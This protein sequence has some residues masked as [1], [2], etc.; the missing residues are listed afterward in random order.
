VNVGDLNTSNP[1]IN[2]QPTVNVGDVDTDSPVIGTPSLNIGDVQTSDPVVGNVLVNVGDVK[3][4]GV[5][6]AGQSVNVGGVSVTNPATGVILIGMNPSQSPTSNVGKP[7]IGNVFMG[8]GDVTAMAP[9][10][11][12]LALSQLKSLGNSLSLIELQAGAPMAGDMATIS[13]MRLFQDSPA[14]RMDTMT[15]IDQM[16]VQQTI[17]EECLAQ[18]DMVSLS[19]LTSDDISSYFEEEDMAMIELDGIEIIK[20]DVEVVTQE[21]VY[22]Y[23][24]VVAFILGL[25]LGFVA[26]KMAKRGKKEEDLIKNDLTESLI[27]SS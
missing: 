21:S 23:S 27:S 5:N 12:H 24:L 18:T 11:E 15:L 8:L 7:I 9:N 22:D 26:F 25:A 3:A 6:F 13:T 17:K 2:A 20:E 16:A 10:K 4:E 19:G 1:A 14:V